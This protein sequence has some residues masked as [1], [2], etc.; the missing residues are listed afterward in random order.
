MNRMFTAPWL[1][2]IVVGALC[3]APAR[4][5]DDDSL[6]RQLDEL[7]Q[8]VD[9]M[10]AAQ[11]QRVDADVE[12]YLDGNASWTDAQ[13]GGDGMTGITLKAA[14][15]GVNQNTVGLESGNNRSVVSGQ[16]ELMFDFTVSDNVGIFA[17]LIANTEGHLPSEFNAGPTLAGLFDGIGVDSS[18]TTRPQGGVQVREAGIR[19]AM[20]AGN[21]TINMELGLIDPRDRFLTSAFS[22]DYRT[23]F[24]HNEFVDP[25]A[26]SWLTSAGGPN[27]LGAYFWTAFGENKNFVLRAGWFNAEGRWFDHGQLYIEFHWKGEVSG[28][29]MNAKFMYMRDG[30]YKLDGED[31]NCWGFEWDWMATDNLGVYAVISGNTEGSNPVEMAWHIGAVWNGVGQNRPDDQVGLAFG[32]LNTNTD[33]ITTPEDSE[34]VLEI[35]Y[36]YVTENGKMQITPH[37]MYVA[38]PSGGGAGWDQDDSLFILG[39]RIH[40][41]F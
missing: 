10:K 30:F 17:D 33:V 6:R 40:V 11:A 12:G 24:L 37:I 14:V 36:K 3:A 34:L 39:V 25:S 19:Y 23:Q 22:N 32:M 31:D 4:A 29:A 8:Q 13:Q 5:N 7:K 16:V 26:V 9:Q 15:T 38:D 21:M 27:S 1:A 35:Y 20:P 2:L 28:R 41:P 18:V